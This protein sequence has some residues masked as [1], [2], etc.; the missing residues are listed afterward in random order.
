MSGSSLVLH[1]PWSGLFPGEPS[2]H[3]IRSLGPDGSFQKRKPGYHL[4]PAWGSPSTCQLHNSLGIAHSG[5]QQGLASFLMGKI[6]DSS[7]GGAAL[8]YST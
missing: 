3:H 8:V 6:R 5:Q 7:E 1:S 4:T 2:P